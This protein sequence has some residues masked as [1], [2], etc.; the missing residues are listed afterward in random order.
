MKDYLAC[1]YGVDENIGRLMD[2]LKQSGLDKNTIVMY[3]S[4][5]GFYSGEHGWFDKRF[6]PLS[7]LHGVII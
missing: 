1:V 7:Y 6:M 2:Y 3:S 4:D 5:Q